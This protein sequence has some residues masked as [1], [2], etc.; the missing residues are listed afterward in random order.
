M[1]AEGAEKLGGEQTETFAL[2]FALPMTAHYDSR[3]HEKVLSA[4][5]SVNRKP[6]CDN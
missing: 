4:D 2:R 1:A 5:F 6:R 3:D